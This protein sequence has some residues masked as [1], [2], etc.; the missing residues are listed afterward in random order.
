MG[1]LTPVVLSLLGIASI[2]VSAAFGVWQY[3]KQRKADTEAA[4]EQAGIRVEAQ[5]LDV[6][7]QT[8]QRRDAQLELLI[9]NHLSHDS[10]ERKE[11]VK[12]LGAIDASVK[13][14]T[15]ALE[16]LTA[17]IEEARKDASR[18]AEK[19]YEKLERMHD[20]IRDTNGR[21]T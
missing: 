20:R 9:S 3:R 7:A 4:R 11:N 2:G 6:L 15:K 19:L 14:Q 21:H 10:A 1:E 13:E 18:R 16:G 17:S 8:V 12:A 5:P